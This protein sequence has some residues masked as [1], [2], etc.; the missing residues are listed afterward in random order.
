MKSKTTGIWF[1][2]AASLFAAIWFHHKYLQPA[3]NKVDTLLPGLRASAINQIQVTPAGQRE[4]VVIR[5]NGMWLLDKP[6]VYPAQSAAVQ[7]LADTL[8]KLVP[9]TRLTAADMREHKNTDAEFGFENPQFT[10]FVESAGQ[11]RQLLIGNKTAPGDQVFIRVVGMDGAF[12][13]DA[14]WLQVLPRTAS[15]WRDTAL[16]ETS[17][18]CDLIVI[19]NG[20]K[21]LTMEFRRD[22]TNQS[23]RMVRPLQTRADSMRLTATL[24]Q[25]RDG[26]AEQFVTDD[27]RVDLSTYGLQPSDLDVWIGQGTN[28]TSGVSAGKNLT[29]SP[30]KIYARRQGWNAVVTTG[31]DVFT[32]WRGGV[33]DFRDP[34]LVPPPSPV[35]EIEV[36]G[37]ENYLLQTRGSNEWTVAGEK[38][39]AD[40]ENVQSFLKLLTGLRISEFVKD[41]V[42]PADLQGFGLATPA[43]Q[44]VL[45]AKPGDTNAP[46]ARLLFGNVETNRALVKRAD[47]DFVYA[48]KIEDLARLPEHGWE[49][50]SRRVWNFSETNIAQVTL[51][52]GGKTR[53]LIRTGENKWSLGP[54]SQGIINPPALEETFHRLGDLN[55]A[56]WVGRNITS[57]EKYGLNPDNLSITVELT[58]GE[59]LT[60][61][62]GA[63]LAQGQTALAAVTLDN[64]RWVFVFPPTL[65][66]FV[67]TYL[68][69]PPNGP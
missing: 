6:I 56:G 58:S 50:R 10:V 9:A 67:T 41:V 52:Q 69:L 66:Q 19:T 17:G 28:L 45:R 30:A 61:N 54:G 57:P 38:F 44:I 59:K 49:F 15:D 48:L 16:V 27:P 22:A 51:R 11:R 62:F 46:L 35:A 63:E 7:T 8:E 60:L 55:A 37:E 47:E 5:S 68:T 12:V 42:T 26:R 64:E 2:L 31:K 18:G 53:I 34:H 21:A 24:Q 13:T 20:A 40:A 43:R 14:A 4:I 1:V 25:L 29:D 3:A 23:W 39:P 36:R 65:F 32:P 33:N